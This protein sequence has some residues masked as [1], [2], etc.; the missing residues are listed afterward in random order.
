[1]I[2]RECE[3]VRAR[4]PLW[5]GDSSGEQ[6]DGRYEGC[7]LAANERCKIERHMDLC[8]SCRLY[9]CSLTEALA[10]LWAAADQ[11]PLE[12]SPPSLW[13]AIARRIASEDAP[14]VSRW[15]QAAGCVA[16]WCIQAQMILDREPSF[17]IGWKGDASSAASTIP[18]G[19]GARFEA[20]RGFALRDGLM[21]LL[22]AATWIGVLVIGREWADAQATT[23]ANAAPWPNKMFQHQFVTNPLMSLNWTWM[24]KTRQVNSLRTLWRCAPEA[25]GF[26]LDGTSPAKSSS[27]IRPG[28]DFDHGTPMAPDARD[29]KPVY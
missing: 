28:S 24:W 12:K 25:S 17:R 22:A 2:H 14:K 21:T 11:M 9:Q 3:W 18:K 27:Q 15:R 1:M 7:D 5:V 26:G 29:S 23:V 13:P 19:R 4:L 20:K 16:D 6:S 8:A 10:A